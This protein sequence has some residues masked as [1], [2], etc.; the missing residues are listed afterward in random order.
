M[1]LVLPVYMQYYVM[2]ISGGKIHLFNDDWS[3]VSY[4]TFPGPAY[5]ITNDGSRSMTGGSNI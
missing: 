4:R 3:Y 1:S 5:M 2:D